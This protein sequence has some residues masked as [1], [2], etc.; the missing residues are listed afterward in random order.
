VLLGNPMVS[1]INAQVVPGERPGEA[2]LKA[3]VGLRRSACS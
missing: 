2:V 1:S 3:R